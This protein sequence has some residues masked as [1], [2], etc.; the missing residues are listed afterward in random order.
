MHDQGGHADR[1]EQRPDVPAR[2]DHGCAATVEFI[3]EKAVDF[4]IFA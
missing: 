4:S 2:R 3:T 1:R